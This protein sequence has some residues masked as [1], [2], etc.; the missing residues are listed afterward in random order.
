MNTLRINI[1]EIAS[2]EVKVVVATLNKAFEEFGVDFYLIGARAKDFWLQS[3]K[4]PPRRFTN[5]IDFAVLV[6]GVDEFQ[7]L[8]KFLT[9][10]YGFE[11]VLSVP[12]RI[13]Y[14]KNKFLID[15]LPFGGVEEAGYVNFNDKFDTKI[16]VLG[17]KEVFESTALAEFHDDVIK[18]ASLPGIVILKL[19]SWNDRPEERVR[20]IDDLYMIL[21]YY[22]EIESEEIYANHLD[23]FDE[24]FDNVLAGARV[25]GR[26]MKEILAKS[27]LLK[28]RIISILEAN[29]KDAETSI[30]S[31]LMV[32]G[33]E[34]SA[35]EAL[36]L[37]QAAFKGL[38]D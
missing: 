1:D 9:T 18:I 28:E 27:K 25:L 37:I 17:L 14:V 15:L 6:S 3:S 24:D 10:K 20:D 19:I 5:D 29:T 2:P 31:N 7:D 11:P 8:V 4:I 32:R 26:Q 34:V 21:K 35:E 23:L 13:T 30:M 16:S 33:T 12:H 38:K 22:F 36:K